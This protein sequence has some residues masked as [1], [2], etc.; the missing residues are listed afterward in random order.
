MQEFQR[1]F[2]DSPRLASPPSNSSALYPDVWH[3]TVATL[4]IPPVSLILLSLRSCVYI[5]YADY[6]YFRPKKPQNLFFKK[7]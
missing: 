3:H 6:K 4:N 7:F 5:A 1:N 2:Q